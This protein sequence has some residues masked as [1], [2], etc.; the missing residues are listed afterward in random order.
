MVVGWGV[1]R[2]IV[3]GDEAEKFVS[4]NEKPGRRFDEQWNGIQWLL[5]R[6]PHI[7]L[8]KDRDHP[9]EFLLCVFSGSEASG[10]KDVWVIYSY[11]DGEVHIHSARFADE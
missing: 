9:T 3:L 2:S 8:P 6:S 4:A 11:S 10:T 5:S 7:G 1:Y